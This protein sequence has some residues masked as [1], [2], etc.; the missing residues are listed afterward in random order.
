MPGFR[1]IDKRRERLRQV[2]NSPLFNS[3]VNKIPDCLLFLAVSSNIWV[4]E[5]SKTE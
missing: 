3:L 1:I 5:K 4:L 2:V